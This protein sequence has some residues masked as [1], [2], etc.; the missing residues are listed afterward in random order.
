MPNESPIAASR[1]GISVDGVQIAQFSELLGIA[2][3]STD[4]VESGQEERL[5]DALIARRTSPQITLRRP[6]GSD[7]KLQ[8]WYYSKV[9]K[10]CSLTIHNTTR[11]AA[12][13]YR[14]TQCWPKT[15][16]I[17]FKAGDSGQLME[18]V[19]IVAE[20]IQRVSP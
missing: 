8:S 9:R 10:T 5:L 7:L 19:S 6:R 16:E 18:T 12:A 13:A 1:F 4:F 20:R 17:S 3:S 11:S 2:G 14:L 15:L